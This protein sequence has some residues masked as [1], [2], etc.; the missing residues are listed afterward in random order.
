VQ[1]KGSWLLY[2]P[3]HPIGQPLGPLD[4][5]HPFKIMAEKKRVLQHDSLATQYQ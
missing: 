3:C 4:L 2:G 1:N 5:G